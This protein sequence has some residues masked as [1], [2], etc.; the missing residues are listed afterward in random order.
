GE[1]RRD[2]QGQE[3]VLETPDLEGHRVGQ[4]V[5]DQQGG[6]RGD[7][8]VEERPPEPHHVGRQRFRIVAEREREPV[9][10]G[11]RPALQRHR[12]QRDQRHQEEEGQP[13]EAGQQEQVRGGDA[14]PSP[15]GRLGDR[16]HGLAPTVSLAVGASGASSAPSSA[17]VWATSQ[18]S[19]TCSPAASR[20]PAE[21]FWAKAITCWPHGRRTWYWVPMPVKLASTTWPWMTL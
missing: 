7:P 9:A 11:E 10:G 12:H 1:E 16:G 19:V 3:H 5:P 8:G 20:M 18:C 15:A 13:G 6:D 4:R 21:R 17:K 14:D 2:D